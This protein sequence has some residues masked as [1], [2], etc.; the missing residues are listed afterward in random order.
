MM[1]NRNDFCNATSVWNSGVFGKEISWVC[2]PDE[3]QETRET[4][5]DFIEA[6][7]G[8]HEIYKTEVG[9]LYV[10]EDQ[11]SRKG[12]RRGNLF[13]LD[14]GDRRYCYFDGEV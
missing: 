5:A 9:N 11:Q 2:E 6:R 3:V 14:A 7:T 10:W 4:I 1:T 8:E 13:V 12:K